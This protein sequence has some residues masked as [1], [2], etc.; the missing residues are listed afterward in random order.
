[1]KNRK[2]HLMLTLL[3]L[4]C[5]LPTQQSNAEDTLESLRIREARV[6]ATVKKVMAATVCI[7]DGIG[8]GSGV[9]ID[10]E[11]TVLTAGHVLITRGRELKLIFPDGKEVKGKRLGKNLNVDAGMV[12]II[13][14]GPF[15]FVEL[16]ET[17]S[18]KRG[19]WCIAI[20]HSQGYV[21]GRRPP[22]RTGRVLHTNERRLV[23][24]CALI[25]GDS[26]GP[27][28]DLDGKLIGIHSSIANS[29]AE[30]RHVAVD[31]YKRDYDRMAAGESWGKLA[32]LSKSRPNGPV[33]GIKLD[34]TIDDAAL[35]TRISKNSAAESAGLKA[36]DQILRIDGE[37][38]T[39]WQHVIDTVSDHNPGDSIRIRVFRN[40]NQIT[41]TATLRRRDDK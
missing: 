21:L 36:G 12:K 18:I 3:A 9:V 25:G 34:K 27:L 13:D 2:T 20:G 1:M 11:G 38:M 24:D 22:V 41:T 5:I 14:E 7:T 40:G 31:I 23:T 17:N 29:I 28:F 8:Y 16:G 35:I 6:K 32:E 37:R 33:L 39:D 4:F 19:D 10:K 26:G 15:P 30:N